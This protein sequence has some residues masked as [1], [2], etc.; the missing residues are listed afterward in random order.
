MTAASVVRPLSDATLREHT[1]RVRVPTYDRSALVPSV[2]HL[3]IGGFHRAHQAVYFDDLAQRRL[4]NQWGV[5]G[6]SLRH[7][8][9]KAALDRQDCLFTVVQRDA[10]GDEPRVVG[11]VTRCLFAPENPEAVLGALTDRRT[12]L[13]TLTVTGAGYNVDPLTRE[14]DPHAAEVAADLENPARAATA[15][16][17]LVEAL[18]R[19]RRA[20]ER[21][22]TVLSC[23]NIP[24]NGLTART[25]LLGFA[26]LRDEVLARW[27]DD[28]VAFP[29]SMVDRITP[30]TSPE[31]RAM[32][33]REFGVADRWPVVTEPFSQWIVEDCFCNGRPPLDEL[34]VEFVADA[35]PYNLVKTRLLNAGH[36]AVGYLGVLAGHMRMD[37]AMDDL[38][39]R[40]YLAALMADEVAPLLPPAAGIDLAGY[41]RTLLQRFANPKIAD[42]LSRLCGR[43]STK[44]PAYLL[45]SVIESRRRG[46][47]CPLL[48]LA[49]AGWFRYLRGTDGAGNH[50][51][52]QDVLRDT[53]QPLAVAS[54]CDPRPLLAQRTIFGDLA[55]D[56]EFV[57]AL[58]RALSALDRQGVRA[59]IAAHLD[60]EAKRAA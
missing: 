31:M 46:L 9:M 28:E 10:R 54:G 2:V 16:A 11:A 21:P 53:L 14:F 38:L 35:A 12:R 20:G 1:R 44:M 60:A 36:S 34:G 33:V 23:D 5:V 49:V 15:F 55:D 41:Q 3:G 26:R 13:V 30:P 4:S 32:V 22:F 51:E 8:H 37:E 27:I 40:E 18:A 58:G 29:S 47:P 19:R 50:F 56:T 52:V 57:A 25:S 43:G 59:S 42:P 45:P 48:N 17:L 6:V 39:M 7:P 24:N